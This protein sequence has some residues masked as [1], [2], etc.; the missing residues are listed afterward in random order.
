MPSDKRELHKQSAGRILLDRRT[1]EEVFTV[2]LSVYIIY[3]SGAGERKEEKDVLSMLANLYNVSCLGS[4]LLYYEMLCF[5][6]QLSCH[7]NHTAEAQ[8][9]RGC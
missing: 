5:S 3:L 6:T 4:V 9:V 7:S 8:S 2:V 1:Q